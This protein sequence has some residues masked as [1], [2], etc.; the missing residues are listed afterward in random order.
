MSIELSVDN[1][2]YFS[3]DPEVESLFE[4]LLKEQV[5]VDFMGLVEWFLGVHFSWHFTP[6][7]A[8]VHLNQTGFT[9]NLVEQFRRDTWEPTSAATPYRPGVPID[10]IATSSDNDDSQSQLHWTEA[11]QSLIGSIG[12]LSTLLAL[13]WL[14]STLPCRHTTASLPLAI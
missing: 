14:Q 3:E 5:K 10:L 9:A 12:W 1:F 4:R 13:I 7:K 8:D 2:V 6:S 11:Y